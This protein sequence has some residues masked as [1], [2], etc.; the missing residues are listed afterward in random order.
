MSKLL[1]SIRRRS[2]THR[3]KPSSP[4][5]LYVVSDTPAFDSASIRRLEAEGFAVEYLPF[6][7][8]SADANRDRRELERIIHEREDD[9]EPGE[10][11]AVMGKESPSM[12]T[13]LQSKHADF[14]F[15]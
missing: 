12:Y 11:Y 3:P 2:S 1:Q 6:Q 13:D 7:A 5:R 9:L 4:R 8:Q 10:R 14:L 15:Y